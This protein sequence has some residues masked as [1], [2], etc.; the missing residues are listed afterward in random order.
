RVERV[1]LAGMHLACE[2]ER[3]EHAAAASDV[4]RAAAE[5]LE[6]VVDELDVEVGVVDDELRAADELEELV[7][8]VRETRLLGE[9]VVVDAVHLERTD[10]DGPVRIQIAMERSARR[11]PVDQLDAA[12]FNDAVSRGGLEPGCFGI[13]DYLSRHCSSSVRDR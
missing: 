6:L 2:R 13:E 11:P 1:A 7:D 8:D 5:K 4:A 3:V 9:E 10:L 12:D